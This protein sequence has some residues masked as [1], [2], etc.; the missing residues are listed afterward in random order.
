MLKKIT[1]PILVCMSILSFGQSTSKYIIVDQFGYQP[2]SDKFAIIVD[3]QTGFNADDAYNP[4]KTFEVINAHTHASVFKGI[5]IVWNNGKIDQQAGD[6]G[7]WFDFSSVTDTGTYYILDKDKNTKS[8]NF[9]IANNVYADALNAACKMFYYN[10]CNSEKKTPYADKRWTDEIDFTGP[11][12]DS[13][14]HDIADRKNQSKIK[15]LTGGWWDAGDYNKYVTFLYDVIHPMVSAYDYNPEAFTDKLNIPE[16]KNGIPDII[17]EIVWELKWVSKMQES[18]GGVHIKMGETKQSTSDKPSQSKEE[19]FYGPVCSSSTIVTAGIFAHCALILEPFP[20]YNQLREDLQKRA[21]LA[22]NWYKNN[23]KCDSCDNQIIRAGDADMSIEK[24][25]KA[26]IVAACYLF[27]LTKKDEFNTYLLMNLPK[28]QIF[29]ADNSDAYS[30][31]LNTALL[32]YSML[33]KADSS[34]KSTIISKQQENTR[35]ATWF[36]GWNDTLSLYRSYTS[37]PSFHWGSTMPM[38]STGIINQLAITF[39]IDPSRNKEFQKKASGIIHYFHGVNPLNIVYLSNMYAFGGDN[40][41]NQIYH[42]WF[43]N[44][45]QWDDCLTSA[46]PPPG[47]VSGGP[48]AAYSNRKISPPAGQP[49]LKAYKDWNTGWPENSWEITEPAIYYQALYIRLLAPFVKQK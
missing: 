29:A 22:W 43:K 26:A 35:K 23:P 47:Y 39:N 32:E 38:S 44:G 10:R 9:R 27:K 13:Q 28:E 34:L 20:I 30:T 8:F 41:V 42:A 16:S 33:K 15:D 40:C 3:P 2:Q 6:K 49:V 19:R 37:N 45:S 17:D 12:Q 21:I 25:N 7:W 1:I 24:Q 31:T 18:D 11:N 48:N 14:C 36:Y 5:P 4:G 46:G